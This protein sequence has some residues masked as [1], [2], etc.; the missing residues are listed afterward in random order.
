VDTRP[1]F[2]DER[3]AYDLSFLTLERAPVTV[4]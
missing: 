3:N 1:Y 4:R 2:A